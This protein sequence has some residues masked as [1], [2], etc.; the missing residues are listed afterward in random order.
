MPPGQVIRGAAG[1]VRAAAPG[2][3]RRGAVDDDE[4]WVSLAREDG[5]RQHATVAEPDRIEH[6]RRDGALDPRTLVEVDEPDVRPSASPNAEWFGGDHRQHVA[7]WVSALLGL[8]ERVKHRRRVRS[9]HFNPI[10]PGDKVDA[11]ISPD[12]HG[13]EG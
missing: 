7:R 11:A 2:E 5:T 10:L 12:P 1:G 8:P 13:G 3:I 6:V 4:A 9:V